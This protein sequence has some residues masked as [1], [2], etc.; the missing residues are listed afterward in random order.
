MK[1]A[2]AARV[3]CDP[4]HVLASRWIHDTAH[5]FAEAM[6][7]AQDGSSRRGKIRKH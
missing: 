3:V 6:R 5:V 1:L 2:L 7:R 4:K